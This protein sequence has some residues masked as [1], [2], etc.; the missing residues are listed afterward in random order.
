M[1]IKKVE[2]IYLDMEEYNKFL[3]LEKKLNIIYNDLE[4]DDLRDVVHNL[5][6]S[7]LDFIEYTETV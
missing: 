1:V 3:E 7:V 4:D 6:K 5:T 2:T